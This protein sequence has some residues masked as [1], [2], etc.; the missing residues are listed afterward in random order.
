LK[1]SHG[2]VDVIERLTDLALKVL[3]FFFVL[4]GV[5][6][7]SFLFAISVLHDKSTQAQLFSGFIGSVFVASLGTIVWKYFAR[8]DSKPQIGS[9]PL[10]SISASGD[11]DDHSKRLPS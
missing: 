6:V 4:G 5:A 2:Q 3:V 9:S 10:P 8:S 11:S 1:I 7:F